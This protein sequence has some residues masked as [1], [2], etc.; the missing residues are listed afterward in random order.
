M[1]LLFFRVKNWA[2]QFGVDL[3]EYGK[4]MTRMNELQRVSTL[5]FFAILIIISTQ[6]SILAEH[7]S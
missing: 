5:V 6:E 7:H 4:Q 2:L 1:K 3:W